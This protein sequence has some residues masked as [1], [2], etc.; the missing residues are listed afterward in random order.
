MIAQRVK[1]ESTWKSYK[2]AKLNKETS[3]NR[4]E[5]IYWVNLLMDNL[6]KITSD[7]DEQGEK[8]KVCFNKEKQAREDFELTKNEAT[9]AEEK[10]RLEI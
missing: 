3:E 8:I 7:L 1:W 9:K 2:I 5:I 4:K 6:R 10:A